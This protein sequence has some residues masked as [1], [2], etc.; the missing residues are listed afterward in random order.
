MTGR[1][2]RILRYVLLVGI[3]AVLTMVLFLFSCWA[4]LGNEIFN[5]SYVALVYVGL[6]WAFVM[7]LILALCGFYRIG[8][9]RIGLFESLKIMAVTT[10]V[11]VVFYASLFIFQNIPAYQVPW[12]LNWRVFLL[13][14]FVHIFLTVTIRFA[15]RV[16][17]S[18]LARLRTRKKGTRC[19]LLG[20]GDAAKI[21]VDDARTNLNAGRL[22]VACL[23]DDPNKWGTTIGGIKVLGPLDKARETALSLKVDEIILAIPSLK[24]ERYAQ[25]VEALSD[26]DV[27]LRKV[28]ALTDLDKVNESRVVDI[29]YRDLLGRPRFEFHQ[30]HV[31]SKFA[32]KTILITGGGGSIGGA[33]SLELLRLGAKHL[34]LLDQY[35]NGVSDV[36]SRSRDL[37]RNQNLPSSVSVVL[38]DL[39]DEPLLK[40]ALERYRPDYVFHTAAVK[41]VPLAQDHP[42]MAVRVNVHATDSLFRLAIEYAVKEVFY[43][44]TDKTI[45]PEG[46]M[47]KTKRIGEIACAYYEG[48]GVTKFHAIRFGNVLA[49]KG[50]VV[51]LFT[52]QIEEGGPVTVTSEDAA[53]YFFTLEDCVGLILEAATLEG[54]ATIYDLEAGKSTAIITLAESLIR[55][56][57]YI[58]HK[59]IEI[60]VT[61]LRHGES[62]PK[63]APYD[64]GRQKATSNHRIYVEEESLAADYPKIIEKLRKAKNNESTRK[65]L[66]EITF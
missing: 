21:L 61:G 42:L 36:A 60:V 48:K 14:V 39:A 55:Q 51:P 12:V 65:I 58:P 47:S 62:S 17:R 32:G 7:P 66:E 37:I 56:A 45:H 16:Y 29:S 26:L 41:H 20:A 11:D 49:S 28:P 23:D 27:R 44:S 40:E 10:L 15:P 30:D 35:E 63:D 5:Y 3:D 25:I 64:R 59:D 52:K 38:S 1:T 43:L 2:Q 4:S 19:L 31:A 6:V 24:P 13:M 50:S 8:M 46:V 34:V 33:L 57:G 22:F 18:V 53:R 54:D 9:S